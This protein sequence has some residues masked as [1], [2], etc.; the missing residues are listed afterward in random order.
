MIN[1][2]VVELVQR[3]NFAIDHKT[4]TRQS[5]DENQVERYN[6]VSEYFEPLECE[7][8]VIELPA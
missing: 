8:E 6:S 5:F 4:L 3:Y 1:S 2:K 7:T